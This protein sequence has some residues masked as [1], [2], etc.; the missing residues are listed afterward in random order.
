MM[1]IFFLIR[2]R[3]ARIADGIQFRAENVTIEF[4]RRTSRSEPAGRDELP[5]TLNRY[6]TII[7]KGRNNNIEIGRRRKSQNR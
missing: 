4:P 5:G 3:A 6:S 1:L 2:L 7:C